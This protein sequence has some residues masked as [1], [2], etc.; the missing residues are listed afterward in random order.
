MVAQG[1]RMAKIVRNLL[2][3]AR[4][5][6]PERAAVNLQTVIEQTLALRINQL[7]LSGI[8]VETEFAPDLPEITGDAQQLEQVFLNLLL[9]A[10]QAILEAQPAGPHHRSARA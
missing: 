1:D 6:P 5:R 10:E 3:F 9:N 8:T 4:Q 2:F 7:T